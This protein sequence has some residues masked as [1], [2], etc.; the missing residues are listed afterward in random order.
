MKQK[1]LFLKG[2]DIN[3][4]RGIKHLYTNN[5]GSINLI[6][7][8]NNS[9]KTTLLE[10]IF[11]C[12][13]PCNPSL[14][15]QINARRGLERISQKQSTI[16][17]LHNK[18][19]TKNVISITARPKN[20]AK[21]TIKIF[22]RALDESTIDDLSDES[23]TTT[24]SDS[25][26][27]E[28]E[29]QQSGKSKYTSKA[30]VGPNSLKIKGSKNIFSDSVYISAGYRFDHDTQAERYSDLDKANL[31]PTYEKLLEFF[32]EK[33]LRT[34][35]VIENNETIIHFDVGFGLLP[36][37]AL[38]SGITRLSAILLALSKGRNA[39]VII[40]E[41]E[42]AFHHSCLENVWASISELANMSNC[43]VF[44]ATHSEECI[45]AA[46]NVFKNIPK[47]D[48]RLHRLDKDKDTSNLHTFELEELLALSKS[49]WD[50]R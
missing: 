22:E 39:I 40:D 41:I 2:I 30:I 10:S 34:S 26:I 38:G 29:Y 16:S 11:L 12:A 27:V 35:L 42:N 15:F 3:N 24:P 18:L 31:V 5:F 13:G 20:Q 17:Y 28:L 43:Q 1:K 19:D 21:Y 23:S 14:L 49:G 44:A 48:F 32:E 37:P 9:G 46:I 33:I 4:F 6:T 47:S 7:G 45:Q 36:L 25:L 50:L 8:K